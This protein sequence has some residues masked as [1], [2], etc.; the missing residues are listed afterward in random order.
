MFFGRW[1]VV[2]EKKHVIARPVKPQRESPSIPFI[3]QYAPDIVKVNG[4]DFDI[5]EEGVL[6]E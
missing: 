6:V 5:K 4:F 1:G 2:D 3:R